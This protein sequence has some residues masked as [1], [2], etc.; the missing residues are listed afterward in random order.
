MITELEKMISGSLYNGSDPEIVALRKKATKLLKVINGSAS[1][2]QSVNNAVA[3]LIGRYSSLPVI[4]PPFYCD[5]GSN[6]QLGK[7]VYFNFNC[8]LLDVCPIEIGDDVLF[9]PNVQVYAAAH[10]LDWQTR[11]SGLEFGKPIS[12]GNN[13]WIGGSSVICPGVTIGKKS[14]VGA[15]S[16]ITKDIPEGVLAAGNPC[17]IIRDLDL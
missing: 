2:E 5:Y 3:N 14:V 4:V 16:V 6:I 17:R 9:G 13:V 8:V 1:D 10:P 12:I 11:A 7:N 15:G